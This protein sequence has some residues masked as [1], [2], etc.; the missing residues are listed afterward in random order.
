MARTGSDVVE[1]AED[2]KAL[3]EVAFSKLISGWM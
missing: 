3:K 1:D 2:V